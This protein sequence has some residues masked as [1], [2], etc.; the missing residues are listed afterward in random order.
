MDDTDLV[1]RDAPAIAQAFLDGVP[2]DWTGRHTAI[3]DEPT[4]R[5]FLEGAELGLNDKS[6]CEAAGISL[7]TFQRWQQLAEQRPESAH[8]M[9]VTALKAARSRGK[10]VLLRRI[11]AAAEKPQFWTAAAW[12]LERT[13]PEQFALRKD[14][15]DGPK[16]IVQIGAGAS[17]VQVG[18]LVVQPQDVGVSTH[19]P[20][21]SEKSLVISHG[22]DNQRS[23]NYEGEGEK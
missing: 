20:E 13:D 1:I 10:A 9:F 15:S 19:L 3:A 18:V 4:V 6:L 22:S 23:V 17:D 7:R 21:V 8:G 5:T 12:T 16:V 2:A 11:A 14:G